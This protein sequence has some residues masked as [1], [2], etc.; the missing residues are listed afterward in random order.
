MYSGSWLCPIVCAAPLEEMDLLEELPVIFDKKLS[1]S[2]P[3]VKLLLDTNL[4]GTTVVQKRNSP[5]FTILTVS[6]VELSGKKFTYS[7]FYIVYV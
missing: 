6:L 2:D 3:T 5:I 7:L 4:F 1:C